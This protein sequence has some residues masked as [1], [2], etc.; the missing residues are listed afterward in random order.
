[1]PNSLSLPRNYCLPLHQI[2]LSAAPLALLL[3]ATPQTAAQT[4]LGDTNPA[5]AGAIDATTHLQIGVAGVGSMTIN[6]GESVTNDGGSIG[7]QATGVGTVTVSDPNAIWTNLAD[8]AIGHEGAGTLN[9][10]VGGQVIALRGLVGVQLGST[11]T[12]DISGESA[13]WN[14]TD[15]I[16][17]QSGT[18]TMTV[19]DGGRANSQTGFVGSEL[20]GIGIVTVSGRDGNGQ[21]SH[22][23][24]VED[25]VVGDLGNGTLRIEDGGLVTSE[26]GFIGRDIDSV[27]SVTVS[28]EDSLWELTQDVVVGQFGAG[29]LTI[30]NG[31]HVTGESAFVGASPGST[32]EV[33][34]MGTDGTN[35]STLALQF[36]LN[37]GDQGQ[38]KLTATNGG[39][40]DVAGW[41]NVGRTNTGELILSNGATAEAS[42]AIIGEEAL[43]TA[44]LSDR[45]HLEVDD[46]LVIGLSGTGVLRVESGATI[47]S[48]QGYVGAEAGSSGNVTVSGEDSHWQMTDSN[49]TLGN[50]GIGV[51]TIEDGGRV[52]SSGAIYLGSGSAVARGTLNVLGTPGARGVIETSGFRGAFGTAELILDGGVV[53]AS[54]SNSNFFSVYGSQQVVLDTNGGYF[55]T[56]NHDIGIAPVL[57]GAGALTKQGAGTLTLTGANNYG[58]GTVIEAGTLRLG[59][60]GTT[61]SILG[62]VANDGILAFDRSDLVTFTGSISGTG[63]VHQIGSGHT[64]LTQN[65]ATLLGASRVTDGILSVNDTLG[66]TM[67]VVG[68]RLQGIGQ[69]GTTTNQ[70][71]GT[72]APGNSIGT[73]TIAGDYIGAGGT[74]EIETELGDDTSATDR[75][76]INGNSS[77]NTNLRVINVG[78][79]GAQTNEGIR[80]VQIGGLA[81]G[82]FSLLGNYV[83]EGDQAV[84]GGAYAYRLYQGGT[85]TPADGHWYLRSSLI[86]A[87]PLYQAGAPVY[88]SYAPVL[89]RLN[90]LETLQQR[91]GNRNWTLGP[92]ATSRGG[93]NAWGRMAGSTGRSSPQTSTSGTYSFD[94]WQVQAGIDRTLHNGAQGDL[95]GALYARYGNATG[96]VSSPHGAGD[97]SSSGYGLGGT[98]TWY[99]SQGSYAD[100]QGSLTWYDS[101]L[102]SA[103]AQTTLAS[104][105]GALGY[106]M[107]LEAGHRIALDANWSVTPQAQIT[108]SGM[109][110]DPFTDVFGASI[111][112]IDGR[113]L[114]LRVGISADYETEWQDRQ[115]Q[116][117]RLHIYSIADLYY[118]ALPSTTIELSGVS[119]TST[120]SNIRGGLGIGGTYSWGDARYALHG[121]GRIS[122]SLDNGQGSY[123]L[124]G[125]VGLTAKY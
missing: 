38:G 118:S 30:E 76:I 119:L 61:G 24:V 108:Y 96:I 68:G 44:T 8:L 77:G 86:N 5:N 7:H 65:N 28:G 27:G 110:T 10:E 93:G 32:G 75:L 26:R 107:G 3:A 25:L 72:I 69:V 16:V 52:S 100:L 64:I 74:L 1:M 45:A 103:T 47:T 37:I 113:D 102:R 63:G 80:I 57:T 94:T 48:N 12:L 41:L 18:G 125:T 87:T 98:L 84:V 56:N 20:T 50:N 6:G 106:A 62:N 4:L 39:H 19:L 89:L 14:S 112:R 66:G 79:T 85:S 117:S 54:D 15:L 22:W 71:G 97:I 36:D 116:T 123:I 58:G 91:I 78:G 33:M 111:G 40:V 49:L 29:T 99:G 95:I 81:D 17:G 21:A 60:G 83:F 109:N 53:R 121:Q 35:A 120:Q 51:M 46:Q 88:E 122:T 42:I 31:G 104:G 67:E 115:N 70:V 9:I 23:A 82:T 114:T 55:D 90:E 11:G 59:D 34:I 43:G 105:A 92:A 101:T 73:L 124:S 13:L 2:L